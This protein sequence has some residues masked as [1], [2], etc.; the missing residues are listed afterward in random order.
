MNDNSQV[1]WELLQQHKRA[2]RCPV[3]GGNGLVPN[4]YYTQCN[5][6]HGTWVSTSTMPETCRGCAGKGWITI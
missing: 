1:N 2:E 5:G 6:P 4:G 3:C